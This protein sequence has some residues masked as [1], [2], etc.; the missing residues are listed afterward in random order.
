RL[1]NLVLYRENVSEVAVV[2]L[3]PDMLDALGLDQ[4]R[5]NPDAIA[6][7][8]QTAFEHIAHTQFASDLLHVYG[9]A[10][11]G[12]AGIAS[13]DEQRWVSRQRGDN[14]LGD[15]IRKELLLGVTA[16]IDERQDRDGRPVG[17][18]ERRLWRCVG[19]S[20]P[21]GFV[22]RISPNAIRAH[23]ATNVFAALLPH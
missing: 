13:D 17:K 1:G 6:R 20:G 7:L 12:E 5:S 9:A 14:V 11:V 19:R 10:L 18:R 21:W 23:R 16:H 3:G 22:I 2:A 15:P 8:A 4:L